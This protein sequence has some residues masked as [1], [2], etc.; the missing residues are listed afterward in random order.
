[1]ADFCV[2]PASR[3]VSVQFTSSLRWALRSAASVLTI[4]N[5]HRY[6][7]CITMFVLVRHRTTR[8]RSH[9]LF[10]HLPS[11]PFAGSVTPTTGNLPGTADKT[12][13]VWDNNTYGKE[14]TNASNGIFGGTGHKGHRFRLYTA[15][16]EVVLSLTTAANRC[17]PHTQMHL[18]GPFAIRPLSGKSTVTVT[19]WWDGV[20]AE[21]FRGVSEA[22]CCQD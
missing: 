10:Y 20:T 1:M 17:V 19:E 18:L 13:Y 8:S 22:A 9:D 21:T 15:G 12:L 2:A 5:S 3:F 11:F 14:N 16:I 4:A 6:R 7:C